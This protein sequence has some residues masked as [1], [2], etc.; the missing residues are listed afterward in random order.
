[1]RKT[2]PTRGTLTNPRETAYGMAAMYRMLQ[3]LDSP[4]PEVTMIQFI[5]GA[6]LR[7]VAH[8]SAAVSTPA[9]RLYGLE[10]LR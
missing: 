7:V 5:H 10:G 6:W 4:D 3:F 1:M 2:R 8:A 9:P